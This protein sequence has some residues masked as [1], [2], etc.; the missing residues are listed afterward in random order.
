MKAKLLAVA[1]IGLAPFSNAFADKD[2]G[3]GLG[4]MLFHGK[5]GVVFKVLGATTNGSFGNQTFGISSGTLGCSQDGVIASAERRNLFASANVDQLASEF[6]AGQGE[7]LSTLASLYQI[8]D[9]DRAAFYALARQQYAQLFARS[10]VTT[11]EV[12]SGLETAMAAD[13]RLAHYV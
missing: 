11:G 5:S 13:A 3:C 2:I 12:L 6:A 9:A 8:S 1:L 4:T 7:A 10:D